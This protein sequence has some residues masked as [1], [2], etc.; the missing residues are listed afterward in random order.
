[1]QPAR[2]ITTI[3]ATCCDPMIPLF[4]PI[5]IQTTGRDPRSPRACWRNR[6]AHIHRSGCITVYYYLTGSCWL[7]RCYYGDRYPSMRIDG[8]SALHRICTLTVSFVIA[9]VVIPALPRWILPAHYRCADP[10][11]ACDDRRY[12]AFTA[13]VL[14]RVYDTP[15]PQRLR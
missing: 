10:V 12:F 4:Y 5:M 6:R 1:M 14:R 7:C 9:A 11:E 2:V 8:G 15:Q 13:L 3:T